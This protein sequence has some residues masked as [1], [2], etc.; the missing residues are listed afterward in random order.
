MNWLKALV[1]ASFTALA[2]IHGVLGATCFLIMADL[3]LGMWAAR[4]RGEPITSAA[5]RRTVSK[6]LIYQMAI[7]SAFIVEHFL[8]ADAVPV[9]KLCSGVIGMVELKSILEN[10]NELNG[11]PLFAS[12][13]KAIGS[14]NDKQPPEPPKAG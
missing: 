10:A 5:L 6:L 1:L 13:L 9:L 3:G 2:P 12:I 14:D 7:I 11:S 8:M 4:K